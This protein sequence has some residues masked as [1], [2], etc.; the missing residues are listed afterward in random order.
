MMSKISAAKRTKALHIR[1]LNT[2]EKRL[3][4]KTWS[5]KFPF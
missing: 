1:T 2:T 5:L 4:V 3:K